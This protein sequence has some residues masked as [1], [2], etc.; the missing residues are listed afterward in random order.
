M[1]QASAKNSPKAPK[2]KFLCKEFDCVNNVLTY[3]YCDKHR[4]KAKEKAFVN[5][6]KLANLKQNGDNIYVPLLQIGT[7]NKLHNEIVISNVD[8]DLVLLNPLDSNNS[9][10]KVFWINAANDIVCKIKN[11]PNQNIVKLLQLL[12]RNNGK[13]KQIVPG[14]DFTRKNLVVIEEKD[15]KKKTNKNTTNKNPCEVPLSGINPLNKFAK[16]DENMIN[17][18]YGVYANNGLKAEPMVWSLNKSGYA[19]NATFGLMHRYIM[20]LIFGEKSIQGMLVDHINGNRLDNR[21]CNLRIVN[22]KQNANNKTN[23]PI[24]KEK[25]GNEIKTYVGVQ[26]VKSQKN[27]DS[28]SN[29]KVYKVVYKNI[30]CIRLTDVEMCALCYDAIA[31]YCKGKYARVNDNNR[32]HIPIDVL[33]LSSDVMEKLGKIKSKYSEYTGI[34]KVGDKWKATIKLDL[35]TFE[36]EERAAAQ[37]DLAILAFKL[38]KQLNF[39][40]KIYRQDDLQRFRNKFN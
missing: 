10:I 28:K 9:Q 8:I 15:N 29:E 31:R 1:K 20:A 4:D 38:N 24:F 19:K 33:N 5:Q 11:G 2:K 17:Y 35:G 25:N 21:L 16:I 18:I 13:I 14:L 23:D 39:D 7:N 3:Q 37:Y 12:S 22:A 26:L 30:E 40:P 6:F 34:H 27:S 36:S 32:K